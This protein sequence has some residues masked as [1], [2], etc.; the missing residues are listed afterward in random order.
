MGVDMQQDASSATF[1]KQLVDNGKEKVLIDAV[2]KF[3]SFPSNFCTN[4]PSTEQLIQN[5][6]PQIAIIMKTMNSYA[7]VLFWLRKVMM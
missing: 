1:S 6:F 3:I 5:V 4:V 7:N 2:T